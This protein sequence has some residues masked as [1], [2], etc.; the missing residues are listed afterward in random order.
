MMNLDKDEQIFR[1]RLLDQANTAYNRGICIFSDFLNLNEQNIYLSLKQELPKIKY[2]TYGGFQDA[3]R[4][5]LCFCGNDSIDNEQEIDYPI[6]CIRVVPLN[7]KFSDSLNHRDFLGAVLNL[8][9]DRGKIGD[10]LINDNESYIFTHTSISVY[11]IDQLVKVKHT[12]IRAAIIDRKDFNYKPKFK[13]ITG[14]V[15]SVRLDSIL[16][17]AFNTSRSSLSGLIEG[18]K[19]YVG[20][21]LIL[22]NSYTLK[23]NDV[24]SV[25]GLGKFIYV[26][27]SYQT[28]KGRYSVKVLL[29]T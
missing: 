8:G 17:V 16:A 11:I 5:I 22:S 26:G 4:K 14:T 13:E 23:E 20:G 28:K 7:Q 10:I 19:V 9:L 18:G 1:K 3:E 25:R 29:Y 21:K 27:T 6:S 2:F 24:V 15:S 12:M